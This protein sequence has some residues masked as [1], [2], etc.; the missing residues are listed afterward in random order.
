MWPLTPRKLAQGSEVAADEGFLFRARP[1]LQPSFSGNRI[2]DVGKPFGIDRRYRPSG[3][4]IAAIRARIVL[5]DS[6]FERVARRSDV[7]ALIKTPKN[8]EIRAFNHLLWPHPSRRAASRFP[9]T[10][11]RSSG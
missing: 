4:C 8:V 5:R 7:E 1:S 10:C 6:D 3:R 11:K 2:G 9:A